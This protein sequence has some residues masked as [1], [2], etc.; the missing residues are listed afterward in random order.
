[1]LFSFVASLAFENG[2]ALGR[3]LQTTPSARARSRRASTDRANLT[4]SATRHRAPLR[5]LPLAGCI[6]V[7]ARGGA[8]FSSPT[9]KQGSGRLDP[10]LR[11]G[12]RKTAA[13]RY[14]DAPPLAPSL[15]R[16]YTRW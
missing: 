12:L 8:G 13:R 1:M 15:F 9:R 10:C 14:G 7:S 4:P 16:P 11:V 2:P 5:C 3:G 6:P